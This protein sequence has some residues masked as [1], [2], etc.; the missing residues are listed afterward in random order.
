MNFYEKYTLICN[1]TKKKKEKISVEVTQFTRNK[2]CPYIPCIH[3]CYFKYLK[4][5]KESNTWLALNLH[6]NNISGCL[7]PSLFH[8]NYIQD[9]LSC[10]ISPIWFSALL[11]QLCS[12]E[13]YRG[14]Y[15]GSD[16]YKKVVYILC[17]K[18]TH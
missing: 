6:G 17:D 8:F 12:L 1:L 11:H 2:K 14:L 18:N 5:T 16:R 9:Y 10:F 4:Y 15:W 7:E 3:L 13:A